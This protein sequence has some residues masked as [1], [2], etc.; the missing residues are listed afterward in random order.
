MK[1]NQKPITNGIITMLFLLSFVFAVNSQNLC[2]NHETPFGGMPNE[3]YRGRLKKEG[4]L[5]GNPYTIFN[6]RN[7]GNVNFSLKAELT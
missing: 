7:N 5:Y 2:D 3:L 1:I 6:K 4:A